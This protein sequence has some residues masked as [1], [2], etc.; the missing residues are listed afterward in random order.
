[1]KR[2]LVQYLDETSAIDCPFGQVRRVITGGSGGVANVHVVKV[3]KGTPH[4]HS[5][6][7]EVYYVLN[8]TGKLVVEST[9]Y[10]LRPGAVAVI[11]AGATHALEG[12]G[13]GMLEFIIFGVPAM[14]VMDDRA[15][16]RKPDEVN[17]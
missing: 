7:D 2:A 11:P 14:D 12:D 1:M 16:P 17:G 5:A 9:T 6:Y 15:R 10:A 8:G 3:S 13:G 4:F